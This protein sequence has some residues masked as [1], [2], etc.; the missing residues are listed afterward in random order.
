MKIADNPVVVDSRQFVGG[1]L[2]AVSVAAL[3]LWHYAAQPQLGVSP[4]A[5]VPET[6]AFELHELLSPALVLLAFLAAVNLWLSFRKSG[7]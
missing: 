2:V 5:P 1:L 4:F 3:A 7:Q 6:R